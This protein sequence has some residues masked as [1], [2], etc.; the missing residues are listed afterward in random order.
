MSEEN[1]NSNKIA[2]DQI[3][4][5]INVDKN[6]T[7][8]KSTY[9]NLLKGV[10]AAIAIATFLG[11]YAIGTLDDNSNSYVTSEELKE[12]ISEIEIKTA[13][14]QQTQQPTQPAV[15]Q[16]FRVF[17][18]D[19]P[20]KGNP[21]APVTI[22]EFSDFQ[23]PFCLRFFQQTLPLIEQN[24]IDTGKIKF[25]YKDLPLD[26]LHP[27]ARAAHIAAECADEQEKFWEYHDVLFEKQP[28]WSSLASSELENT[29]TE[30]ATDM[31]LQAASFESC[32]QSPNIAD[33]VNNDTLEAASF[34]ATGTPTF[35]IGNEK[36]GFI[37]LV[38]AQP[39]VV[40]QNVIDN[41]LG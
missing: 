39:F 14:T 25:V 11:G 23:C 37:K 18:D 28:Q 2:E 15:P 36:D 33:E 34:G 3:N 21:D 9:N 5:T 32:M 12:M 22:V 19:D 20:V 24:Y 8:K 38:G 16:V 10:I 26:S 7:I 27:N 17:L 31:G 4:K 35:F 40:F 6:I 30:F 13:P 29:F 41:Q 1:K